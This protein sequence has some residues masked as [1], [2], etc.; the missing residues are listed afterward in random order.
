MGGTS[1]DDLR[2]LAVWLARRREVDELM[3]VL[4]QYGPTA[5]ERVAAHLD[6]LQLLLA[7]EAD[8]FARYRAGAPVLPQR[9]LPA[10]RPEDDEQ[11]SANVHS[12]AAARLVRRAP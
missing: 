5:G 7:A 12:L 11:T 4:T 2:R 10:V 6:A 3:A 9:P 8:A 1:H